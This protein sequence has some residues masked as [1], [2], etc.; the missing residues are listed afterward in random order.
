MNQY[1]WKINALDAKIH[2]N[3]KNNVIYTVHWSYIAKDESGDHQA[4]SI[5]TISV[6]YNPDEPFIEYDDLTKE[7]V[8]GWLE[9]EL[10]VDSMKQNLDNQIEL[11]KKP[12]DETLYPNWE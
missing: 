1:N 2:E 12:V 11:Q 4:S 7:D 8:V 10:D 3:D 5:G 9:S 6:E